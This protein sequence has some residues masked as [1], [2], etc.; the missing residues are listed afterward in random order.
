MANVRP[1][2]GGGALMS[3]SAI[4]LLSARAEAL[5]EG[6]AL[7]TALEEL[8]CLLDDTPGPGAPEVVRE[9]YAAEVAELR[10][11]IALLERLAGAELPW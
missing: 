2:C 10:D 11:D 4:A 3:T 8:A 1:M 6:S 9:R 7:R 5:P